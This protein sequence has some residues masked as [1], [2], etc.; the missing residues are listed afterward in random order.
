MPYGTIIGGTGNALAL[1]NSAARTSF[2]GFNRARCMH[3]QATVGSPLQ[4][5]L[6]C[7]LWA[8]CFDL[9][10]VQFHTLRTGKLQV[11]PINGFG[12][13]LFSAQMGHRT[14]GT[15]RTYPPN[16][17]S[18]LA[19]LFLR[20]RKFLA[21]SLFWPTSVFSRKIRHRHH[22]GA[23]CP[24][25]PSVRTGTHRHYTGKYLKVLLYL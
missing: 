12:P 15:V 8:D 4:V 25:L 6:L 18:L 19:H 17:V 9:G 3:F 20:F 2:G 13:D 10:L 22:T 14:T 5:T 1:L 7:V 21:T 16:L 11:L 24:P 23:A